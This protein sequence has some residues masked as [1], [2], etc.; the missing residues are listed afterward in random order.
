MDWIAW[1]C[2]IYIVSNILVAIHT[3]G[4]KDEDSAPL[5]IAV[6]LWIPIILRIVKVI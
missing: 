4:K 3:A 2:L 1:Y 5:A 6:V